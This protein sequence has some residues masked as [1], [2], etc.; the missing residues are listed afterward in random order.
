MK[1]FAGFHAAG[2]ITMLSL[3]AHMLMSNCNDMF[4]YTI[5]TLDCGIFFWNVG[6]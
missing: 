3:I 5:A 6:C 1:W 2:F 4:H